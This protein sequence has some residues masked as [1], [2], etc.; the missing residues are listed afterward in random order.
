MKK[1]VS[2]QESIIDLEAA[3]NDDIEA[4]LTQENTDI[5][6]E[7][8]RFVIDNDVKADWA[9][10]KIAEDKQEFDRIRE[11]ADGQIEKIEEQ[12]AASERRYNYRTAYLRSLLC[13]YFAQVPHRATKTQETYQLLSGKLVL[14]LSRPKPVYREDELL[15]YLKDN[16]LDDYVKTEEKAKWGEFKKLIDTSD[17]KAVMKD[18]GEI[19][20]CIRFEQTPEEFKVEV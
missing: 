18:T 2:L 20:D 5:G 12:K 14:K 15:Q 17:N 3:W 9:L 11:L 16:G 13:Q 19:I 10:R 8:M 6:S 1:E 7:D 4:V